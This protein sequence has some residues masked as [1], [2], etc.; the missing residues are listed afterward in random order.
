MIRLSHET[1][2]TT[3]GLVAT[4]RIDRNCGLDQ[5]RQQTWVSLRVKSTQRSARAWCLFRKW[6][7][8]TCD[9]AETRHGPRPWCPERASYAALQRARARPAYTADEPEYDVANRRS[10][11]HTRIEFRGC[12]VFENDPKKNTTP[13]APV[14]TFA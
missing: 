12:R 13:C 11:R 7:R 9:D 1:P 5:T 6:K 2:N 10:T 14:S 3:R 4:M 8:V